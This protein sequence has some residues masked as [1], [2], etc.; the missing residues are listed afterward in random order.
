MLKALSNTLSYLF[1]PLIMA[2]YGCLLL[3]FGLNHSIYYLLTP[4]KL[5][6][7]ITLIVFSFTFLLP[8]FNILVLYKLKYISSIKLE[9]RQERFF[10]LMITSICYLGLFYLLYDFNIWPAIKLLILG[11]GISIFFTALITLYW[12]I[13]A[14]MIGIGG[15]IGSF[16]AIGYYLQTDI[17]VE[18]SVLFVLAGFIGFSRLYLKAHTPSQVYV[19]F[20]SACV[21][22]I[23]LFFTAQ[24]FPYL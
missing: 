14:H 9:I 4:F 20:I 16:I 5:K 21:F 10:P 6:L 3:F 8:V 12:Q 24:M 19:G 13:S 1:H 18:V 11:A 22:Q 23:L 17:L 7:I 2:T 15:L